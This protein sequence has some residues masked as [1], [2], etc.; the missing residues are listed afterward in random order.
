MQSALNCHQNT[1][2]A[3]NLAKHPVAEL[4]PEFKEDVFTGADLIH[5]QGIYIGL[6]PFTE[7]YEI[8]KLINI[9][10]DFLTRHK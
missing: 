9:L 1:I 8:D 10:E 6:S 5:P 7:E 2:Q 3:D 4:F